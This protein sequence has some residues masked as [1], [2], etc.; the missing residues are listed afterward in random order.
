MGRAEMKDGARGI[1]ALAAV[2]VL[3]LAMKASSTPDLN[4]DDEDNA[5]VVELRDIHTEERDIELG[6]GK[7]VI[8]QE[9]G[10]YMI[11]NGYEDNS[12]MFELSDANAFTRDRSTS[13]CIHLTVAERHKYCFNR[14]ADQ[15][16]GNMQDWFC[17]NKRGN[18]CFPNLESSDDHRLRCT[19]V[20]QGSDPSVFGKDDPVFAAHCC[21]WDPNVQGHLYAIDG[22]M[23]NC[24][25][26]EEDVDNN[27]FCD[28]DNAR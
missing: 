27:G 14:T 10:R 18:S 25:Y 1:L 20:R 17:D 12:W 7:A 28:I 15:C 6:E 9:Y 26:S 3:F 24:S 2:A 11:E 5:E 13:E 19:S 4:L 23:G 8:M 16:N 22:T 21:K